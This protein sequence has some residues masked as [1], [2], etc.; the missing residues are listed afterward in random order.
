[1]RADPDA[2]ARHADWPVSEVELQA[3]HYWL[4]T[5]GRE[6]IAPLMMAADGHCP[7]VAGRWMWG[8]C[9]W[10][11]SGFCSGTGPWMPNA[12]GEWVNRNGDNGMGIN[13]QLPHLGNNGRGQ[14]IR[15][16][17]YELSDR[18]RDTWTRLMR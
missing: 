11:G 7:E 10:I 1:V 14:F 15:A 9:A 4:V 17:M 3:K 5:E 6:R 16:W 8:L 18:L 2:V 12:A 13:K